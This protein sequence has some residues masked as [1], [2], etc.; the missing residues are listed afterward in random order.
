MMVATKGGGALATQLT[1]HA[2]GNR[3][4]RKA[5]GKHALVLASLKARKGAK[6][7]KKGA[8]TAKAPAEMVEVE[9]VELGNAGRRGVVARV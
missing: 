6:A 4:K 8:T 7:A 3:A 2:K 5:D 1:S 9:L